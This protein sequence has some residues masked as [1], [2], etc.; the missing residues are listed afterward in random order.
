MTDT[1]QK[2]E[3]I[4]G[5]EF[6]HL[7]TIYLRLTY[8]ELIGLIQTGINNQGKPIKCRI[9]GVKFIH[10]NPPLCIAAAYTTTD[11]PELRRKWL[12]GKK[13]K[14]KEEPG[15]IKK[16]NEEFN[17]WRVHFPNA[18]FKLYLATNRMLKNDTDLYRDAIA[19]GS[20]MGIEIEIIEAS[21][22]VSFLDYKPEG[23][24]LCQEFLGISASLLSDSMLRKIAWQSLDLHRRTYTMGNVQK[25]KREAQ[26][27]VIE[28][29][30][31]AKSPIIVVRG[32]SGVGKSTLLNQC[33]E[34]LNSQDQI[35]IWVPSEE[36]KPHISLSAF[37]LNAIKRFQPSVDSCA[38]DDA[39][40]I[41][42]N[43]FG[44]II[45]LLDDI[46]RLPSPREALDTIRVLVSGISSNI[47]SETANT[48]ISKRGTSN[49]D[50]DS[51]PIRFVV[52]IW[53]L[54]P[55]GSSKSTTD[56]GWEIIDLDNYNER[57]RMAL[58]NTCDN[59]CSTS[60]LPLI[61]TFN[62]DP[63]LCGLALSSSLS[64]RFSINLERAELIRTVFEDALNRAAKKAVQI[65]RGTTHDDFIFVVEELIRLMLKLETPESTWRQIRCELGEYQ[66]ELLVIL[67]ETNQLGWIDSRN[68]V[69][70][71]SWKHDR[72]RD[73]L[74]GRWLASYILLPILEDKVLD[75]HLHLLSDP[76]L[77]SAWV[78]A[79]IF[80]SMDKRFHAI[81]MLAKYQP[82]AL[83]L[84]LQLDPFTG[85]NSLNEK[86]NDALRQALGGYDPHKDQ[87]VPDPRWFLLRQLTLTNNPSVLIITSTESESWHVFLARFRNGEVLSGLKAIYSWGDRF[88]PEGRFPQFEEAVE[89]FAQIY[90][91]NRVQV[92][93]EI[94]EIILSHENAPLCIEIS[95]ILIG[96]LGW[97]E[98]ADYAWRIWN[99]LTD[100][101]QLSSL[102]HIVWALNRCAD[103]SRQGN[104]E[105]A[106]LRVRELSTDKLNNDSEQY[107]QFTHPI[108]QTLHW[109]ITAAAAEVWTKVV[110][111]HSDLRESIGPLLRGIDHP[112][113]IK[114]Y[115]E[116][117]S[118]EIKLD[119][120]KGWYRFEI[121]SFYIKEV[122]TNSD[123]REC[124]WELAKLDI[125]PTM[126]DLAFRFWQ[127]SA[128]RVDIEKLRG[129]KTD[130]LLFNSALKV[131]LRLG[132]PKAISTL[133]ERIN[134][135]PVEWCQHAHWVYKEAG[136]ADALLNNID[137]ILTKDHYI[138]SKH[139]FW[140]L[141]AEGIKRV[142]KEK[143]GLL[144]NLPHTWNVLWQ[145][146][147]SEALEFV[148]Q[149]LTQ[150]SNE[151]LRE[152]FLGLNMNLRR[153]SLRMLNI[154]E[155]SLPRFSDWQKSKLATVAADAGFAKWAQDHSL[156]RKAF[157]NEEV[158][159]WLTEKSAIETLNACAAAVPEGDWE[160][161]RA[162]Y[163]S[164]LKD[165]RRVSFDF[166]ELLKRWLGCS[167][168]AKQISVAA[169]LMDDIGTSEDVA[170]WRKLEPPSNE[171]AHQIW[172][173]M[174][175][176][177]RIRR[178]QKPELSQG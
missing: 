102:A 41:A 87:F 44:G 132:D 92:I 172:S 17:P 58:A 152:F 111:Q 133:I 73:A 66:L 91:R 161:R 120:N 137:M 82:L 85:N 124:L 56:I 134:T 123:T 63:F 144:K 50:S 49:A 103:E 33:G 42:A 28:I 151:D 154:L 3:E 165:K 112:V 168:N 34:S 117:I 16:A 18:K 147:I 55:I 20:S 71:W 130:D 101:Q 110:N 98:L 39:L 119:P 37:L 26:D 5:S 95:L 69:E 167:P 159:Y 122:P 23:Q 61:N 7:A 139:I 80:L 157:K 126:R 128:S 68:G 106:L 59:E 176:I 114:K 81:E 54:Q 131:R 160:V 162:D 129:I 104:L 78:F 136:V 115:I 97:S 2:L 29:I 22:L 141:P 127:C 70:Y 100:E 155:I 30:E 32:A 173:N 11:D 46:N 4:E 105:E 164:H 65:K 178:W 9:D 121:N 88:L 94:E 15:D 135:N 27:E 146:D 163:F 40:E 89:A 53:P 25:I 64:E 75:E 77:A 74:V 177:L 86:I 36:L 14:G 60:L 116:W 125:D 19:K 62:G 90:D 142:V 138:E 145:S 38:G 21:Q 31:K 156:K 43:T 175:Y 79:L 140:N 6:E 148:Q 35:C 93:R 57:E 52:P 109:K 1:L 67:S 10:G 8:P 166:K 45:I 47:Q 118:S 83:A 170:W 99:T 153:V 150:A 143:S 84:L 149:V 51:M 108:M 158:Q 48:A 171:P 174:F 13:G 113:T 169:M 24:Y 72:L 12:G 96:Y 76:G 107:W